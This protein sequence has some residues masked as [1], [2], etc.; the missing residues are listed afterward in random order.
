MNI[1]QWSWDFEFSKIYCT[2]LSLRLADILYVYFV[3]ILS[4]WN[5]STDHL[6]LETKKLIAK[7]LVYKDKKMGLKEELVRQ[8]LYRTSIAYAYIKV[9]QMEFMPF[10]WR[11]IEGNPSPNIV[12][13]LQSFEW[14]K[15]TNRTNHW[16]CATCESCLFLT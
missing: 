9:Q 15:W 14:L 5:Y 4:V 3:C 7:K 16:I 8:T 1:S 2:S 12:P 11:R 13:A 6:T 10:E